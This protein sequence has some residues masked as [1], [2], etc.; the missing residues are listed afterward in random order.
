[1]SCIRSLLRRAEAL[2]CCA[3]V[4]VPDASVGPVAP[5]S[6]AAQTL[7]TDSGWLSRSHA[8]ASPHSGSEARAG[9]GVAPSAGTPVH[10]EAAG[11]LDVRSRCQGGVRVTPGGVRGSGG[12]LLLLLCVGAPGGRPPRPPPRACCPQRIGRYPYPS[13]Q[14]LAAGTDVHILC[15]LLLFLPLA[16]P[17]VEFR[18]KTFTP[19]HAWKIP[20]RCP[21]F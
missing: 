21:F 20:L 9:H 15:L 4:Q 19:S 6:N 3:Q 2:C 16:R 10:A 18:Q 11:R 1:M 14:P 17:P 8:A 5:G 13:S 7:M 12:G